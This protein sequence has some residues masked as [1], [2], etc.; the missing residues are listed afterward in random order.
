MNKLLLEKYSHKKPAG[1]RNS[2][3]VH[4]GLD[5]SNAYC[6]AVKSNK[7]SKYMPIPI[8]S[9]H[10]EKLAANAKV[11]MVSANRASLFMVLIL[12]VNYL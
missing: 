5:T 11:E 6:V 10:T 8:Y 12:S 7:G 1:Q 2:A 3:P 4:M 9:V